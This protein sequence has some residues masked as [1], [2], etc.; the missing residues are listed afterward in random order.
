MFDMFVAICNIKAKNSCK[1]YMSP[2]NE[3]IRFKK[4]FGDSKKQIIIFSFGG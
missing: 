2:Y 4:P 3:N 1:T